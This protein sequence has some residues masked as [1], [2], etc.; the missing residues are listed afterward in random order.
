MKRLAIIGIITT[1]IVVCAGVYAGIQYSWFEFPYTHDDDDVYDLSSA[2]NEFALTLYQEICAQTQG[3]IFFSPYSIYVALAMT[4]E[5]SNSTTQE[6]MD[7]VLGYP[8]GNSS[9]LSALRYLWDTFN[10]NDNIELSTANALW[11]KENFELLDTYTEKIAKYFVG[12]VTELDFS[13]AQE[14]ADTINAWVEQ[15]T[16]GKI[17]DLVPASAIN[18]YTVL[19]LTNA[20]YFKGDWQVQFDEENTIDEPFY[21]PS[22]ESIDVPLM[23]LIDSETLF[24]YTETDA[25]QLLELPYAG[26]DVSMLVLLPKT[27]DF[28]A[29]QQMVTNDQLTIWKEAMEPTTIDIYFP[30]FTLETDYSL[31]THLQN[32]GM[33][34]AFVP[35]GADFTDIAHAPDLYI[36]AVLHKAFIEVNEQGTEAAAA[37][38]VIV[39]ITSV[40]DPPERLEF[41]ADHS[42][43]FMIQHKETGNILFMGNI[44]N[45]L[46]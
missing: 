1:C 38:A 22:G 11:L 16:N 34:S 36:T 4:Y 23:R 15:E 42:F 12:K 3:N 33:P 9:M 41:R 32:M 5:G 14:A 43:L 28:S 40:Q 31:N 44:V 24:N 2:M 17:K 8:K 10:E 19:I 18:S 20:I 35:G 21:L 27:D 7:D 39:G 30:K 25:F 29:V 13:N 37:T 26:N 46:E 6:E 45:P